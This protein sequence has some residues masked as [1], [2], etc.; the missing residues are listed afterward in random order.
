MISIIIPIYNSED[1]LCDCL[2]S[3]VNSAF[4]D[5]EVLLVDDGSKDNSLEI[6]EKYCN[7]DK[8]FKVFHQKNSG[9]SVARNYGLS[10]A[11]GDYISFV[12]SDDILPKYFLA[13]A[14]EYIHKYNADIVIGGYEIIGTNKKFIPDIKKEKMYIGDEINK[15]K[16]FFLAYASNK[17]T[18]EF[19]TCPNILSPWGKVFKKNILKNIKFLNTLIL[20]EDT[21]FNLYAFEQAE[22]ILCVPAVYYQWRMN[23]ESIS[24]REKDNSQIIQIQKA[25]MN[26]FM[27]YV[28]QCKSIDLTE[29]LYI[30]GAWSFSH[31]LKCCD[32]LSINK[33]KELIISL[34]NNPIYEK[35]IKNAPIKKYFIPKTIRINCKLVKNRYLFLA[36]YY[37]KCKNILLQLTKRKLFQ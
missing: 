1:Y 15:L 16:S 22:S 26:A 37:L 10:V 28:N 11:K 27:D 9:A 35:C 31:C 3:I 19:R 14:M 34:L 20:D 2:N 6:C 23:P 8:R 36:C 32:K 30:R 18:S 12:D 29:E 33:T 5:F 7:K 24:R 21:L 17:D 4:Q 13:E 25:S